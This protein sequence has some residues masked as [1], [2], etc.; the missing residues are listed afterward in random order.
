MTSTVGYYLGELIGL[1]VFGAY[2]KRTVYLGV[3][4][5]FA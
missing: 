4:L 1:V 3:K 5:T 2:K